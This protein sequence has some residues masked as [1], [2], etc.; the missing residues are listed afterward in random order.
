MRIGG[1]FSGYGGLE[2]AAQAVFGGAVAWHSEIDQAASKILAHHWPDVPNLG[3]ITTVDWAAVEPVDVLTG[4]SPC[5]DVSA[6]GKRAGMRA[7]TRSGLWAAMTDAIDALRPPVVVWENVRGVLSAEADSALEPCTGCVG[8]MDDGAVLRALGRV[9]G[10]LSDLGYDCEC[11][12][13]E[14]L[15]SEPHTDDSASSSLLPTPR[16]SDTN[17]AGQHG[18]GGPD[19]RTVVDLLPTPRATDG[20]K[21]GPNQRGSSGDLMLPSAVQALLPTPRATRGGSTTETVQLLPTPAAHDSG[22][23]PEQHLRKKPGREVVTSLQVLIEHDLI[24]T[25]GRINQPSL[26]GNETSGEWHHRP[27]SGL[28]AIEKNEQSDLLDSTG[29]QSVGA[30]HSPHDHLSRPRSLNG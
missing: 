20:T 8:D 11:T 16:T 3:D 2:M 9:L 25:G 12:A 22:N 13:Y 24:P 21:G 28:K 15:T 29:G 17:G 5:Q 30:D 6:A 10:D 1:L 23:T 7:G 14:P 19:L 27:S 18:T 4:G 26:D